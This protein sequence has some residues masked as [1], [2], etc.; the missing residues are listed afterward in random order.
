MWRADNEVY[1]RE[2]RKRL[3]KVSSLASGMSS[4]AIRD[5]RIMFMYTIALVVLDGK[6]SS[7]SA[8]K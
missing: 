5:I 6:L 3:L 2:S 8:S 4:A 1:H 7:G